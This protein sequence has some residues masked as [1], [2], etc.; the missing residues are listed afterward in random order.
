MRELAVQAANGTLT[1]T[2][3][4]YL[5]D[6]FDEL[7]EEID[8]IADV[9]EFN[10]I[11][12]LDGSASDLVLQVG[13]HSGEANQITVEIEDV[14]ADQLGGLSAASLAT[15]TAAQDALEA[16]DDAID[17]ISSARAHI[18][19]TQNRLTITI[20][21]LSSARE[22]FSAANSRIRDVDVAEE[23]AA[24]TRNSILMQAGVS[25]LAQA[26][27]LPA[28]ALSLIG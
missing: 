10:G 1:S 5:D 16:I 20:N 11:S 27:M 19:A 18:G 23:T 14:H 26:N 15:A 21:N 22:N 13:I 7:I 3:R 2:E 8:R 24:L 17:D 12:L 25:V 28:M 4:G 9:T 6:E